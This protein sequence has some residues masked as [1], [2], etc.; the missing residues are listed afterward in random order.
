[1][2]SCVTFRQLN[3]V[4]ERAY[5]AVLVEERSKPKRHISKSALRH[6]NASSHRK[7]KKGGPPDKIPKVL[8]EKHRGEPAKG[9]EHKAAEEMNNSSITVEGTVL[10]SGSSTLNE[11]FTVSPEH[12]PLEHRASTIGNGSKGVYIH[13]RMYTHYIRMH[14]TAVLP[15]KTTFRDCSKCVSK[16]VLSGIVSET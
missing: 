14:K 6:V 12:R 5:G 15:L 13:I 2:Y 8:K 11:T 10:N 1:M 9:Q 3:D 4:E 7:D 16:G